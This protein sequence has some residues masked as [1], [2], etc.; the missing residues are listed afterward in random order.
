MKTGKEMMMEHTAEQKLKIGAALSLGITAL[1]GALYLLENGILEPGPRKP[2]TDN[3]I[4]TIK[5]TP[6]APSP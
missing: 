6:P 3:T 1:L 5:N 2:A 4:Q